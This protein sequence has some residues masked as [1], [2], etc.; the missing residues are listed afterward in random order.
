MSL[1]LAEKDHAIA[2]LSRIYEPKYQ[3]AIGT[4]ILSRATE[5]IKK[6]TGYPY[7]LYIL[8][9]FRLLE[10]KKLA[11]I[12]VVKYLY[13]IKYEI[14]LYSKLFLEKIGVVITRTDEQSISICPNS[15]LQQLLE[16]RAPVKL[17]YH[18]D[19]VIENMWN[20]YRQ[21]QGI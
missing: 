17:F 8:T 19:D 18:P 12:E 5:A 6:E 2:T 4:V 14:S 16:G 1:C 10:L 20:E 21:Q 7:C 11:N 9:E 3:K 13:E 15:Y